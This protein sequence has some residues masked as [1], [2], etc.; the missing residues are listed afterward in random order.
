MARVSHALRLSGAA[1][2]GAALRLVGYGAQG[3]AAR[4]PHLAVLLYVLPLSASVVAAAI[5]GDVPL[6]PES[7]RRLFRAPIEEPA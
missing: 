7:I 2:L 6:I 1:L 3:L 4:D 5:L